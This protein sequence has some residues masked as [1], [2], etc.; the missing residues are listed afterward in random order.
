MTF[1]ELLGAVLDPR[2]I[3]ALR[4]SPP[5]L[6][7]PNIDA[8]VAARLDRPPSLV[9]IAALHPSVDKEKNDSAPCHYTAPPT[10]EETPLI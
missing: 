8:D 3:F 10:G 5:A 6:S 4:A 9:D 2:D 1:C 7:T